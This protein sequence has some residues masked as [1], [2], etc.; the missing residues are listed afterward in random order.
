MYLTL[1]P[2]SYINYATST[3]LHTSLRPCFMYVKHAHLQHH[4]PSIVQHMDYAIPDY[5]CLY[6][7]FLTLDLV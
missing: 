2:A 3:V 5:T 4:H 7:T 6:Q 1:D